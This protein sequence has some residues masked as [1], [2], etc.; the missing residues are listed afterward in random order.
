MSVFRLE[1]EPFL[2]LLADKEE[3]SKAD[4]ARN[5]IENYITKISGRG[6]SILPK[7]LWL[8]R[9]LANSMET[10]AYQS[11]PTS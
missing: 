9:V 6:M 3:Y 8:L 2:C 10:M 7:S 11:C 5:L 4:M 1:N